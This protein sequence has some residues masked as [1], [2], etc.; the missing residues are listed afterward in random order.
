MDFGAA[1]GESGSALERHPYLAS[2]LPRRASDV[3]CLLTMPFPSAGKS[4]SRIGTAFFVFMIAGSLHAAPSPGADIPTDTFLRDFAETRRFMLGRPAK[5]TP[6]ADGKTVLFLRAKSAREP[7]QELFAFDIATGQTRKLLSPDDAL[8]GASEEL[9]PEEKA[10]RERQRISVGG[11]TAFSTSK[12]SAL[13]LLSLSDKLYVLRIADRS[14]RELATGQGTIVDP[15]FAPDSKSVA[16]V[17]NHDVYAVDLETGMERAVTSGGTEVISHGLAEFVAQEEM[18]RFS[19]YWWSPDS[20]RIAFEESDTTRVETWYAA[21]PA[22]PGNTPEKTY[23]PRPGKENAAVRVGIASLGAQ[24]GPIWLDWD[25]TC[26]P[27][28]GSVSWSE[29]RAAHR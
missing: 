3:N 24:A 17:R 23:Y 6:T 27:Y 14:V 1:S 7:S 19:G 28:L 15:K 11:F 26:Y 9:S 2:C 8:K 13:V 4:R 29:K 10:R 16:Y 22:Q 21:D 18:A 12:D 5:A 25:R 20:Q